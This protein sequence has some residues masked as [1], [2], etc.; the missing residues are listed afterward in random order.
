M[1]NFNFTKL[2]NG[3]VA[4]EN[5]HSHFV[6]TMICAATRERTDGGAIYRPFSRRHVTPLEV[7]IERTGVQWFLFSVH[8]H[9]RNSDT[10]MFETVI[11]VTQIYIFNDSIF[12]YKMVLF[13]F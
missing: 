3:A 5:S 2:P 1:H 6:T 12:F 11:A 8:V 4:S 10:R 13:C 7:P 9:L